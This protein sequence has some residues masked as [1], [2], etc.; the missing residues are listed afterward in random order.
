MRSHHWRVKGPGWASPWS[1]RLCT[2]T[3]ALDL[4]KARERYTVSRESE[5][6]LY[7]EGGNSHV[8]HD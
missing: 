7:H 2:V 4:G 3:Q 6:V 8:Q 1:N 5:T